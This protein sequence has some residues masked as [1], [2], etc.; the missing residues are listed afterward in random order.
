MENN[1]VKGI[2]RYSVAYLTSAGTRSELKVH[3]DSE[4]E[5]ESLAENVLDEQA[6]VLGAQLEDQAVCQ[7]CYQSH[8]DGA[9]W[10]EEDH[11]AFR[12]EFKENEQGAES[13]PTPDEIL[14]D[15]ADVYCQKNTD[16]GSSWRLAGDTLAIWAQSMD[17]DVDIQDE[18]EA[19]SIGLYFQRMHKLV[20]GFNLE[21]GHGE[22]K[23]EPIVDSHEDESVYAAMAASLAM[24]AG[25]D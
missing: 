22:P 1:V 8:D 13:T 4:E 23:N 14:Q 5:A 3:A 15:G 18:R 20:R 17:A 24:E 21:F 6:E 2:P 19:I 7:D 12:E 11:D 9:C 16:Y 25:D 10:D